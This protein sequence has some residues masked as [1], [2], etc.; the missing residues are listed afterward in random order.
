MEFWEWGII[1]A[2]MA[3][4]TANIALLRKRMPKKSRRRRVVYQQQQPS[5]LEALR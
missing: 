3:M 4:M 1:L 2:N 5:L